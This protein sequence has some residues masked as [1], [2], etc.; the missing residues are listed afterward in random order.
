MKRVLI[1]LVVMS[2]LSCMDEKDAPLSRS[3]TFVRYINGGANDW[4]VS[5]VEN[6]DHSITVLGNSEIINTEGGTTRCKIKLIHTDRFGHKQWTKLIPAYNDDETLSFRAN[7][8]MKADDGGYIIVGEDIQSGGVRKV[9]LLELNASGDVT[10]QKVFDN[11][12]SAVTG[13]AVTQNQNGNYL[14]LAHVTVP[15]TVEDMVVMEVRK[16]DLQVLWKRNY[17]SG[18]GTVAKKIFTEANSSIIWGGTF[19]NNTTYD[20]RFI[21]TFPDFCRAGSGYAVA[22]ITNEKPNGNEGDDDIFFKRI[23]ASGT[24]LASASYRLDNTAETANAIN[25]TLDGGFILLGTTER[26]RG[27]RDYYFL[28]VDAFGK[29]LW[30]QTYGSKFDDIGAYVLELSDRSL[31]ILGTTN[32][33][34]FRT[35]MMMKTDSEGKI[36]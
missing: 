14:L 2:L 11:D 7:A 26:G 5:A 8:M 35:I 10:A 36:Q 34:G 13:M 31:L 17:G 21:K 32:L 28:K 25:G 27:E 23:S 12:Q 3:A 20:V 19:F 9:L 18:Q 22:G 30:T 4:A 6:D 1:L 16:T 33:A 15:G 29:L 24:V